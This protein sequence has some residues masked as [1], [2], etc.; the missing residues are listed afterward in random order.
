[1][2]RLQ[3]LELP[4]SA[5]DDRPPFVLI[6][7]QVTDE[8]GERLIEDGDVMDGFGVKAGARAVVV[9]HGMSVDI[10]ANEPPTLTEVVDDPERAGTT[11]LVYAHERTR[12]DLCNALL[13][14]GDTT[15]RK[16]IEAV[17]ERQRELA[18]LYRQ[19]DRVRALPEQPDCMDAQHPDGSGYR[20]GYRVAILD[21]KRATRTERAQ[22][23]EGGG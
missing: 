3:I 23:A 8:E 22:A 7:D 20:H 1:M 19:L 21:A 10:P 14:S 12:L 2:A 15:W 4:S 6:I 11:Q 16:L 18:G 9:F 13:L 17:G 5:G